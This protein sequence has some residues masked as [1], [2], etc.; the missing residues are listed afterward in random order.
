LSE[1]FDSLKNSE[2]LVIV[3]HIVDRIDEVVKAVRFDGWQA[4][5]KGDQL[6]RQSLRKTLYIQFKI[7]DNDVFEKA[8][9]YIREYY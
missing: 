5:M 1:L 4:T 2:T 9:G 6:V 8:L 7:R 3:E